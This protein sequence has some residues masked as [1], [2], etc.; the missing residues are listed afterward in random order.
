[1]F[2]ADV[3]DAVGSGWAA[4][5]PISSG[6]VSLFDMLKRFGFSF[7]EAAV[8]LEFYRN[9]ARLLAPSGYA[10]PAK[11]DHYARASMAAGLHQ[12]RVECEH[13]DLPPTVSMI[14]FAESE[15]ERK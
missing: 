10:A 8:R 7:Y 13:L 12:M 14:T 11:V 6:A 15:V 2:D 3:S 9:Q 1:M 5:R 4:R